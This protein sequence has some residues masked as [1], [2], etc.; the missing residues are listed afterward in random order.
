MS[1]NWLTEAILTATDH[2]TAA[3]FSPLITVDHTAISL[4][5]VHPRS[6]F[7]PTFSL[8][9]Q[10]VLSTAINFGC[11][12]AAKGFFWSLC[13]FRI[14]RALSLIEVNYSNTFILPEKT[15]LRVQRQELR[16]L[17][18]SKSPTC[19]PACFNHLEYLV[20]LK[21]CEPIHLVAGLKL[22]LFTRSSKHKQCLTQCDQ[23]RF[24]L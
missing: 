1:N 17:K 7:H 10:F 11:I 2:A 6:L 13:S 23:N 8:F 14:S 3:L 5:S 15:W 18:E 22:N 4:W 21:P 19:T 16:T 12:A 20:L 9:L 24:T